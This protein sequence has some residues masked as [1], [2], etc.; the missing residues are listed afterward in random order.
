M[1]A[2]RR[3][4]H[5]L[6]VLSL[7]LSAL[8][9]VAITPD[10]GHAAG[11]CRTYTLDKNDRLQFTDLDNASGMVAS[12]VMDGVFWAHNDQ[13][14]AAPNTIFAIDDQGRRLATI[15]FQLSGSDP[16]VPGDFVDF[17]DIAIGPGP[18]LNGDYL[19]IADIGD[20][21]VDRS[22]VALYRF[23]EPSFTPDNNNPITI[24]VAESGI[25]DQRFTYQQ[26]Q[27]PAKTHSR[28]AEAIFV[29][30]EDGDLYI[31]EKGTHSLLELGQGTGTNSVYSNVYRIPRPQ[32]FFGD[33]LRTATIVNYIQHRYDGQAVE[34]AKITGADISHDG[35]VIV[36]RNDEKSFYWYRDR[37]QAIPNVFGANHAAPC[38]GPEESKGEAVA[39]L[40][41]GSAFYGLREGS[42]QPL[43]PVFKSEIVGFAGIE[44][45]GV[46]ATIVGTNASETIHGTGARDV[47][48]ALG[49]NDTIFAKQ[50]N[51]LICAGT[52]NDI[53][54]GGGGNDV[55]FGRAG[56]DR[57]NG[58]YGN[59]IMYGGLNADRLNG[60]WGDDLLLGGEAADTLDGNRGDDSVRGGRGNDSVTGGQ[61]DDDLDG[62]GG[63]DSLFGGFGLDNCDGGAGTDTAGGCQ[64][65]SNIP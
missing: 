52:G 47:I 2:E 15:N 54:N 25:E 27:D 53:V 32:L 23:R 3:L 45:N 55:M 28:N 57:L 49:G 51:D 1:F 46:T 5:L 13:A 12:R 63:N 30:P 17:E 48:V 58:G 35:S 65:T 50:G 38:F 40:P 6:V 21:N 4:G 22:E 41:D 9:A 11:P 36:V 14:G 56:I 37:G 43:S 39:I 16:T 59:D 24:N 19:Y 8:A 42:T 62:N 60:G 7:V 29:D 34:G 64:S 20:N 33:S 10:P 18:V 31:F 44:C 61:D 26:F